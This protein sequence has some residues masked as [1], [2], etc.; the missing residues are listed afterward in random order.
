MGTSAFI[1]IEDPTTDRVKG[2]YCH[3]DG[4]PS[5]VGHTLQENYTTREKI[6]A[7]IALGSISALRPELGERH[8]LDNFELAE[9]NDWT[10]AYHRDGEEELSS[11][12]YDGLYSIPNYSFAYAYVY[13][14][15]GLWLYKECSPS[16]Y[17][18]PI[19]G[20]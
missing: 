5:G 16:G 4:Y 8:K 9:K 14:K 18:L 10:T 6:E 3:W 13:T 20:K 1:G 17:W 11:Y 7:L 19:E 12:D 15:H 2:V